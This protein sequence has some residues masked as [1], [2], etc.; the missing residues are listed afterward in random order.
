[1]AEQEQEPR[2]GYTNSDLFVENR[3]EILA[4]LAMFIGNASS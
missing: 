4:A 3:L 1:L 2:N